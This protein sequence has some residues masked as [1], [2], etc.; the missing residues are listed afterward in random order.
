MGVQ[1]PAQFP[2][3]SPPG[4]T[5]TVLS[6]PMSHSSGPALQV[7]DSPKE[8]EWEMQRAEDPHPHPHPPPR[9]AAPDGALCPMQLAVC[10]LPRLQIN[11]MLHSGTGRLLF[12][13]QE[14][15]RSCKTISVVPRSPP[16]SIAPIKVSSVSPAL[17][18]PPPGSFP[19]LKDNYR[20]SFLFI[21]ISSLR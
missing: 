15:A 3:R 18:P 9:C 4:C 7:W 2:S 20:R 5:R 12:S 11:F 14:P 1:H 19:W 8:A 13:L 10:L 17:R 21:L 16:P 6:A